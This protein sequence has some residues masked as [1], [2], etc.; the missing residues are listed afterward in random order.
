MRV[1]ILCD[2]YLPVS[3]Q[4]ILYQVKALT[5][6]QLYLFARKLAPGPGAAI[7]F[8][9]RKV[10]YH[11]LFNRLRYKLFGKQNQYPG[12]IQQQLQQFV[13][14]C[15]IDLIYVHYGSTAVRYEDAITALNLPVICAFHGFD[16]SRKLNDPSYRQAILNLSKKI[17]Q[18]TVPSAFLKSK[19]AQAGIPQALI[20]VLPYG[21]DLSSIKQIAPQRVTDQLTI[22]HAGRLVAKKGVV[23]LL[24]VFLQ[25]CKAHQ[26]IHLLIIGGG[27]D[28]EVL[29]K[30]AATSEH[31]KRIHLLGPLEH[32]RLISF[33]KGS[34][35][36]VLNSR[37]SSLG[38]TEG[39][40][41]TIIEAMAAK[42]PVVST[43]HSGIP[44]IIT[45]R[46]NGLLVEPKSNSELYAALETLIHSKELR[47]ELAFNGS[48]FA[49]DN[50]SLNKMTQRIQTLITF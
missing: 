50:H 44:E 5:Q 25:L 40:P 41:N 11:N 28:E 39:L 34:D 18:M 43:R 8:E 30:L 6:Y 15:E 49:E 13:K 26:H 37:E 2:K 33:V 45:D 32:Q 31:K 46:N 17:T 23:D 24:K 42:V 10:W 4:F 3:E 27:E 22:V 48:K 19:L 1:L 14:S 38:E 29:Q 35:I 7:K 47:D 36:F 20:T 12:F 9:K 21:T 16:A